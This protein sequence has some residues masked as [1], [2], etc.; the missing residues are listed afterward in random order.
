MPVTTKQLYLGYLSII[1]LVAVLFI[2]SLFWHGSTRSLMLREHGVIEMAS[3]AGYLICVLYMLSKGGIQYLKHGHVFVLLMLFFMFRELDF[4][5]AFTTVGILKSRFLFSPEVPVIEKLIGGAVLLVLVY[6]AVEVALYWRRFLTGL[7]QRDPIFIGVLI[8]FGFLVFSKS[9][10]GIG[11][12]LAPLGIDV[13]ENLAMH[14]G[15]FEEVMELGIPVVLLLVLMAYFAG[16]S[17]RK[18]PDSSPES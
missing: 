4:D 10:D 14:T 16:L 7:K 13:P 5:K 2:F 1:A 11:R 17:G 6:V 8:A 15:A 18:T 12:K 3:A 9:I